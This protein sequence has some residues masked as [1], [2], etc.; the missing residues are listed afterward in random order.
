[1]INT[2]ER[3]NADVRKLINEGLRKASKHY[4][5]EFKPEQI[6][7]DFSVKGRKA[8]E[9]RIH[10]F[11]KF[12]KIRLN[13]ELKKIG[14][15]T[16][17]NTVLHELGHIIA[18]IAHGSNQGHGI[19]WKQACHVIGLANP[20]TYHQLPLKPVGGYYIY[21]C[22]CMKHHLTKHRHSKMVNG[23]GNYFCRK[24]KAA[25]K[26][27]KEDEQERWAANNAKPE[28]DKQKKQGVI[29]TIVNLIE[30]A[31]PDG[32]SKD[33]IFEKLNEQFPE[34]QPDSMRKTINMQVP[35]RITKEK[36]KVNKTENGK[37]YKQSV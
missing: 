34:R 4:G 2:A 32:I 30:N 6:K 13:P 16:L 8:G 27:I 18:N 15:G 21:E 12:G 20:Q 22:A 11:E 9:A 1:M 3:L 26:W 37:Y 31:G 17:E 10:R 23:T 35:N 14:N 24:C 25:L 19:R 29:A 5:I 7:F 33:E 28:K 36:F